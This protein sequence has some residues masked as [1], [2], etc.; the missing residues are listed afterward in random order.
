VYLG[1][2]GQ[3]QTLVAS[4]DLSDLGA[5]P[6]QTIS[7]PISVVA[8]SLGSSTQWIVVGY[9][10]AFE[11]DEDHQLV[12]TVDDSSFDAA[13]AALVTSVRI[14]TLDNEQDSPSLTLCHFILGN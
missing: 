5:A 12:G 14:E 11:A 7:S 2:G 9:N 3:R 1:S 8:Q 6:G 4:V 13:V 10:E